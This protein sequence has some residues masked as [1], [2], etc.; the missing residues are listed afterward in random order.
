MHPKL[1]KTC[2]GILYSLVA[3]VVALPSTSSRVSAAEA[4]IVLPGEASRYGGAQ[5]REDF[6]KPSHPNGFPRESLLDQMIHPAIVGGRLRE[7]A[8]AEP[9][10][11]RDDLR[12][13]ALRRGSMD[14]AFEAALGGALFERSKEVQ[15][16]RRALRVRLDNG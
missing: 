6:V 9:I 5:G 11:E 10:R 14:A 4:F 7:V 16:R 8:V 13:P 3:A 15:L 2:F 1:L 12:P